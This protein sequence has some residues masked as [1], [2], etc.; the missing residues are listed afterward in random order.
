MSTQL[1]IRKGNTYA[2]INIIIIGQ[3]KKMRDR[4]NNGYRFHK[5]ALREN[6]L[7]EI[8]KFSGGRNLTYVHATPNIDL[9]TAS[10]STDRDVHKFV[11]EMCSDLVKWDGRAN[12]G[13]TNSEEAFISKKENT[14]SVCDELYR[15][16]ETEIHGG[17]PCRHIFIKRLFRIIWNFIKVAFKIVG[18]VFGIALS[19]FLVRFVMECLNHDGGLSNE[20]E[21]NTPEVKVG[22]QKFDVNVPKENPHQ[23]LWGEGY[24]SDSSLQSHFEIIDQRNDIQMT[25]ETDIDSAWFTNET[26]GDYLT[27]SV[28]MSRKEKR[29]IRREQRRRNRRAR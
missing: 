2:T 25:T 13:I 5:G 24:V 27:D 22:T 26:Q 3:E 1:Y 17:V 16:I 29:R 23:N 10:Y 7:I 21:K 9:D 8:D 20:K 18:F 12:E 11:K 4:D 28:P 19:I 15:R 14:Q 6:Y